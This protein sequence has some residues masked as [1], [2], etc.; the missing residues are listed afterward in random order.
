MITRTLAC[1][2]AVL[3]L[4]AS[5]LS[6]GAA[7]HSLDGR[8]DYVSVPA[9]VS[10]AATLP[11]PFSLSDCTGIAAQATQVSL[12]HTEYAI[13]VYFSCTDNNIQSPYSQCNDPLFNSDVFELFI[14]PQPLGSD[15]VAQHYIE[16]ELSPF[17]VMFAANV[18]NPNATC[19]GISSNYLNCTSFPHAVTYNREQQNWGGYVD[20]PFSELSILPYYTPGGTSYVV[21]FFRIDTPLHAAKEYSSYVCDGASPACFH[22]PAY[23]FALQLV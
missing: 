5:S 2:C 3:L 21:N 1:A 4:A 11:N 12:C 19:S 7:C 18:T 14:A 10:G 17:D 13:S 6:Q 23:F 9:C 16:L 15:P 8:A 22:M 20:V